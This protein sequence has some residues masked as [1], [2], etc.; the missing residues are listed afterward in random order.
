[1]ERREREIVDAVDGLR[2]TGGLK[3]R[4]DVWRTPMARRH[5]APWSTAVEG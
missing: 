2:G 5:P 4:R 3:Y 1:M